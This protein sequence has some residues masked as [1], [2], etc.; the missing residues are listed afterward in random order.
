M[1]SVI[2]TSTTLLERLGQHDPKAWEDFATKYFW[3]MRRWLRSWEI[4]TDDLEDILQ[5]SCLRVFR[6]IHKFQHQGQG[7]FRAWLKKVSRSCWLQVIRKSASDRRLAEFSQ[8]VAKLTSEET[9]LSIDSHVDLLIEQDL[10]DHAILRTR[11]NFSVIIWNSYRLTALEGRSGA[12]ASELLGISVASVYKN[13][14][15]FEAGLDI[16]LRTIRESE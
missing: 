5:E 4:S 13:R 6:N 1:R 12:F 15:R 16:E 11:R 3:M 9:F 7:S 10:F 2:E 14:E 8:S